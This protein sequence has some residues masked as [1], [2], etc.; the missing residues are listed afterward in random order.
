MMM[1][2]R[3]KNSTV[4]VTIKFSYYID[5]S[6]LPKNTQLVFS[7]QNYIWNTSEIFSIASLV[8][9]SLTSFLCFSYVFRPFFLFSKHSYL[10]NKKK[11]ARWLEDMKFIFS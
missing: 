8:K 7:I 1:K 3:R 9:I 10:C 6:V 2:T 4:K 5:M 11:I